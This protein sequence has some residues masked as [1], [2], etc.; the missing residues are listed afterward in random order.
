MKKLA[1]WGAWTAASAIDTA[2][3]THHAER[4]AFDCAISGMT[5]GWP[6]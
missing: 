2:A 6:R 4:T 5:P 3:R 1:L